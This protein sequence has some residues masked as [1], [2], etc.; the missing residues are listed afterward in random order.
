MPDHTAISVDRQLKAMG[1]EV[2]EV[3]V[4]DATARDARGF[5]QMRDW[6]TASIGHSLSWL[7]QQNT[8]G[9][10]IYVRPRGEHNL[11]LL[12]DLKWDKLNA[13]RKDGFA[14]ALTVETSPGNFQVW[15]KHPRV[16]PKEESTL[17]ARML[18]KEYGGDVGSADWRHFGR[19]AG[20][21]NRKEKYMD[22]T[23]GRY[24]FVT[25]RE[26]TGKTYPA[27]GGFLAAVSDEARR[28]KEED[29]RRQEQWDKTFI[30]NVRHIKP[31][32][33]FRADPRYDG[34]GSR[35]DMAWAIY[36]ASHGLNAVEIETAIRTR[37]LSHKGNERRQSDYVDRTVKNAFEKSR[38]IGQA[39]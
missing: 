35:S 36:A 31:I 15:L 20:F 16:L 34:D 8:S 5:M 17:A 1:S 14:P 33:S 6:D 4:Y 38:S 19:L 24:P 10:H 37:D 22:V 25:L 23:T 2:F 12:D 11:T 29:R 13:L 26:W 9:R 3:G 30:F 21:T 18:A 7:K 32:D 27:A 39:R 28:N